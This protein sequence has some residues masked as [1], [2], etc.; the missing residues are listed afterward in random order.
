M[1]GVFIWPE[2][3]AQ[4]LQAIDNIIRI[5]SLNGQTIIMIN[6]RVRRCATSHIM[7]DYKYTQ[8]YQWWI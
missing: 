6:R 2:I 7:A 3:N 1:Y 5:H 8:R 4:Y